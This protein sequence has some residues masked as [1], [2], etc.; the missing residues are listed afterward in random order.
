M[1]HSV[2]IDIDRDQHSKYGYLTT[3]GAQTSQTDPGPQSTSPSLPDVILLRH[4]EE[5]VGLLDRVAKTEGI[6]WGVVTWLFPT[7]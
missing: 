7:G 3:S 6:I 5:A 2:I 1:C 4:H